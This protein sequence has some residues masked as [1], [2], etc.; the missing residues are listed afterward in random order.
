ME[1]GPSASFQR[2]IHTPV[3]S[4]T[5]NI[6]SDALPAETPWTGELNPSETKW[7]KTVQKPGRRSHPYTLAA[8]SLV[9]MA[10]ILSD[11]SASDQ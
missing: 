8:V 1:A 10:T 4:S 3:S 2:V 9:C 7:F 6:P 5:P 11:T